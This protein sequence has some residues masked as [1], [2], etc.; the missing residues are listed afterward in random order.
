MFFTEDRSIIVS[1]ITL[2][3][4]QRLISISS[5]QVIRS[6][7]VYILGLFSISSFC[8]DIFS[9]KL[10]LQIIQLIQSRWHEFK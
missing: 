6:Q 5:A 7:L 1:N 10:F 3:I 2:Y 9:S 8:F 4:A